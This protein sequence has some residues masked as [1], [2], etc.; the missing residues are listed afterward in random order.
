MV[1]CGVSGAEKQ[2]EEDAK[3]EFFFKKGVKIAFII[4]QKE[5]M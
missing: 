4:V 2:R 3:T 1:F 5:I